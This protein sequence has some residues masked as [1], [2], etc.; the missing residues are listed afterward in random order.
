M[1]TR[2]HDLAALR[3]DVER[4]EAAVTAASRVYAPFARA[5]PRGLMTPAGARAIDCGPTAASD[6]E[7]ARLRL[8]RAEAEADR[9]RSA[10]AI[11][12][13]ADAI[14]SLPA[15]DGALAAVVSTVASHPLLSMDPGSPYQPGGA[16]PN[17][18][19][20][21]WVSRLAGDD[22]S[23]QT[24]LALH[25]HPI[26]AEAGRS[27]AAAVAQIRRGL[28][29][30]RGSA[31]ES[32]ARHAAIVTKAEARIAQLDGRIAALE[33]QRAAFFASVAANLPEHVEPMPPH[34]PEAA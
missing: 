3:A 1:P 15:Y 25:R 6:R 20:C 2:D 30:A 21:P 9:A 12:A 31:R 19:P 28:D 24:R 4:A 8:R 11:A 34:P 14:G 18:P 32:I 29:A 26:A 23:A 7:L 13:F 16:P 10:F 22:A 27:V 33:A 17:A 5:V